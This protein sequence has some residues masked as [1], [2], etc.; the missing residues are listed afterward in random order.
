MK[1]YIPTQHIGVKDYLDL[2]TEQGHELTIHSYSDHSYIMNWEKHS[3]DFINSQFHNI[4][5]CKQWCLSNQHLDKYDAFV[6]FYPPLMSLLLRPFNKTVFMVCPIRYELPY[7]S[8]EILWKSVNEQLKDMQN[9]GQLKVIANSLFDKGYTEFYTGLKVEYIP[10][11][12]GYT[13]SSYNGN[14]MGWILDSKIRWSGINAI[15]KR[16]A[17]PHGYNWTDINNFSG[18]VT[19]PYNVSLMSFYERYASNIPHLLPSKR[20][21]EILI[22]KNMAMSEVY[23]NNLS[24]KYNFDIKLGISN[25]SITE[26]LS[27]G[28]LQLGLKMNIQSSYSTNLKLLLINGIYLPKDIDYSLNNSALVDYIN[29]KS[30]YDATLD[31]RKTYNFGYWAFYS[32]NEDVDSLNDL[33][34]KHTICAPSTEK[35]QNSFGLISN[36]NPPFRL[37]TVLNTFGY[38]TIFFDTKDFE[39]FYVDAI[40]YHLTGANIVDEWATMATISG[41]L[42]QLELTKD[43]RQKIVRDVV[44]PESLYL[45]L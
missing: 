9:K 15:P 1:I 33:T 24:N 27:N 41:D 38:E 8:N 29:N 10:S 13:G 39:S 43:L 2:F 5:Y 26:A 3:I 12:C 35:R 25:E 14:N 31:T 19:I 17:L 20:L 16:Q 45:R 32:K 6:T 42:E 21:M 23:W 34:S 11:W 18:F 22:Y 36:D 7:T 44:I 40:G 37:R 28:E 4:D 30:D